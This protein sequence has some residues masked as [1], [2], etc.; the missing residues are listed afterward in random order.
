MLA[1]VIAFGLHVAKPALRGSTAKLLWLLCLL[2]FGAALLQGNL[3]EMRIH[4]VIVTTFGAVD[5][6]M[7]S[8][9]VYLSKASSALLTACGMVEALLTGWA[10]FLASP[11]DRR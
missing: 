6:V 4:Q 3:T 2:T 7:Y 11:A 8:E 9:H 1:W 10:A 5:P